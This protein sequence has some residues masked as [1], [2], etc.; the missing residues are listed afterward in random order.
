MA[1]NYVLDTSAI[2]TFTQDEEGNRIVEDVLLGIKKHKNIVYISFVTLTEL[3]YVVWQHKGESF[4]KE[5]AVLVKSLPIHRVD[6][7]ERLALLAG[8]IKAN[9]S[10][11]LADSFVAATAMEKEAILVHKDPEFE[12]LSKQIQLCPLPYKK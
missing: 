2:L 4:A 5:L 7:S 10:L 1:K 12:A 3:Y 11:S 6:S 9:Y 8:R